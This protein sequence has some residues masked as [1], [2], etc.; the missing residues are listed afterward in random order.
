[1]WESYTPYRFDDMLNNVKTPSAATGTMDK[2]EDLTYQLY[3]TAM[4]QKSL[5]DTFISDKPFSLLG[6]GEEIQRGPYKGHS[7]LFR[8]LLKTTPL[9]NPYE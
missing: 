4:P 5:L 1:M 9:H 2:V 3:K 7:K 8:S 6:T